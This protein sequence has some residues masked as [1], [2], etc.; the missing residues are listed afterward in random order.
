M[1]VLFFCFVFLVCVGGGGGCMEVYV[2]F[3]LLLGFLI[4]ERQKRK[5]TKALFVRAVESIHLLESFFVC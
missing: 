1:C 2:W 5:D 3:L 4:R